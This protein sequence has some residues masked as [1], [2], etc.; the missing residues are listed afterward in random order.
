MS[1]LQEFGS[2]TV[3]LQ[4]LDLETM[5][6]SWLHVGMTGAEPKHI[7]YFVLALNGE[8]CISFLAFILATGEK[9]HCRR[10][11]LATLCLTF[12]C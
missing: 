6:R 9:M 8:H 4:Q 10:T 7:F 3:L 2:W 12:L 1:T 5:V 11:L